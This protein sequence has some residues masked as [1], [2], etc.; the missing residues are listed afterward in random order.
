MK[1]IFLDV[2][3]VLNNEETFI[4][5][6]K[7]YLATG[8]RIA[9]LD[10]VFVNRLAEIVNKTEAKIVLSSSWKTGWNKDISKCSKNCKDLI[11]TLKKYGLEIFDCT[12]INRNGKRQDEIKAWLSNHPYVNNYVILDDETTFLMDFV[13][14]RLVKT[15]ILPDGVILTKMSD[16]TGLLQEHVDK[17]IEILNKEYF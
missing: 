10:D 1:V 11:S 13:N 16:A 9:K 15:S 2:D 5:C 17:A 6:E 7:E 8:K 3:G 14:N 12:E 4:K